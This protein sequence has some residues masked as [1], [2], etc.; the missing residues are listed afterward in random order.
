MMSQSDEQIDKA[1]IWL[2][3][4]AEWPEQALGVLRDRFS[5]TAGQAARALTMA[6]QF[7]TNRRAVG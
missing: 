5:L 7:K 2:A 4:Q 6:R 3:D 1:A